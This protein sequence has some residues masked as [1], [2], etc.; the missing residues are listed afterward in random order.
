MFGQLKPALDRAFAYIGV[1]LWQPE[2]WSEMR[3][4]A[5]RA[6]G[7]YRPKPDDVDKVV[8]ELL[9]DAR[10]ARYPVDW[11][12]EYTKYMLGLSDTPPAYTPAPEEPGGIRPIVKKR[13]PWWV[14]AVIGALLYLRREG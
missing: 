3:A 2:R 7:G 14:L 9:K 4:G 12:K 11:L 5:I 8:K 13:F 1:A 6:L 10:Y